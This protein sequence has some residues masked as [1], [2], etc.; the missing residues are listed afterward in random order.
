MTNTPSLFPQP[1]DFERRKRQPFLFETYYS[2]YIKWF[3]S[4]MRPALK[5]GSV[6]NT[7]PKWLHLAWRA[8]ASELFTV[9]ALKY[10]AGESVEELRDQ[11]AEIVQCHEQAAT[12]QRE[13]E[14]DPHCSGVDLAYI[15]DYVHYVGLLSLAILLHREDLIPRLHGLIAGSAFDKD[16]AL[17]EELLTRYLRDRPYLDTFYH[18]E[19]YEPLLDAT[20]GDTPDEK[21]ADL[22][23]Y[24]KKWYGG[25]KGTGWYNAHKGMTDEGGGGYFGYWAWEAGAIAYLHGI[26]DSTINS[27]YYPKDLVAYARSVSPPPTDGS[28]SA[29]STLLRCEAGEPCPRSGFWTSPAYTGGRRQFQQGE[30][31]PEIEG[32]SWGATFWYFD[33]AGQ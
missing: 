1:P 12:A 31:M 26:D 18:D 25:M 9:L 16:D 7:E 11:L 3:E 17:V 29:S 10:T 4:V 6:S 8:Y 23:T 22:K 15:D 32:N 13:A 19:P 2:S 33:E 14:G 20:A 5:E 30:I 28:S 27:M 21:L 24:L